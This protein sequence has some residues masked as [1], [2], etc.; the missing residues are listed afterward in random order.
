MPIDSAEQHLELAGGRFERHNGVATGFKCEHATLGADE[1][2][3]LAKLSS[4]KKV[5]LTGCRVEPSFLEAVA[6]STVRYM[7][8]R[9]CGLDDR[10]L[11]VLSKSLTIACLRV[12]DCAISDV[13]MVSVSRMKAL[14]SVGIWGCEGVTDTGLSRLA[15]LENAEVISL[16]GCKR[17]TGAG[18]V[19]LVSLQHL[20][21][22]NFTSTGLTDANASTFEKFPLLTEL[23]LDFTGIADNGARTVINT[24]VSLSDIGLQHTKVTDLAFDG[25]NGASQATS[26]DLFET[27]VTCAGLQKLHCLKNLSEVYYGGPV[28]ANGAAGLRSLQSLRFLYLGDGVKPKER[29]LLEAALPNVDVM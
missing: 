10:S 13:G 22:I 29:A 14:T 1:G 21:S 24:C 28:D 15:A 26:I 23:G 25:L 5:E 4:L 9:S 8:A 19:A 16:R 12:S 27:K 3:A 20:R 2:L 11:E 18:L 6:Q 17:I 7:E